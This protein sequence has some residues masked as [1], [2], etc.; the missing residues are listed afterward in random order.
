MRQKRNSTPESDAQT[1]RDVRR[2]GR[3]QYSAEEKIR[4][5]LDGLRGYSRHALALTLCM[6]MTARDVADTLAL[7][8]DAAGLRWASFRRRPRLLSD[9]RLCY[10][11]SR[12]GEWIKENGI[13]HTRGKPYHPMTQGKIERTTA[14]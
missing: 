8:L 13:P 12:F 11:A 14:K 6:T 5:V 10:V 7:A 9:N 3:Q 2:A 1:A 4:I